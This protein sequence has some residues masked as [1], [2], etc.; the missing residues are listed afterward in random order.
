MDLLRRRGQERL[1][2]A[3]VAVERPHRYLARPS[4]GSVQRFLRDR[5]RTQHARNAH[6]SDLPTNSCN[7]NVER[8]DRYRRVEVSGEERLVAELSRD[9]RA[10]QR[11]DGLGDCNGAVILY[12]WPVLLAVHDAVGVWHLLPN[13][14]DAGSA[15]MAG[16]RSQRVNFDDIVHHDTSLRDLV[17]LPRGWIAGRPE[18]TRPRRR[19]PR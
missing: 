6:K 1:L 8:D 18:C 15:T 3:S 2:Q 5:M 17:G 12:G 7:R 19:R 10:L 4:Y 16:Q 9:E 14:L 11:N 13:H